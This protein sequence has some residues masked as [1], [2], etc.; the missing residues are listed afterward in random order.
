MIDLS[1]PQ[2]ELVHDENF[3]NYGST[4]LHRAAI[5]DNGEV[6]K[7]FARCL[8]MQDGIAKKLTRMVTHRQMMHMLLV[9]SI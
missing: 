8:L 3:E 6:L 9:M 7:R 2:Y 4:V 1:D 5:F